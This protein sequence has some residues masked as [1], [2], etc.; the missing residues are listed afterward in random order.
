MSRNRGLIGIS[1]DEIAD[2]RYWQEHAARIFIDESRVSF[3]VFSIDNAWEFEKEQTENG[4]NIK[5]SDLTRTNWNID[6]IKFN[7]WTEF[8]TFLK[9]Q[10]HKPFVANVEPCEVIRFIW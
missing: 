7:V 4:K 9:R 10:G 6:D 8:T 3:R 1:P 2:I 5:A